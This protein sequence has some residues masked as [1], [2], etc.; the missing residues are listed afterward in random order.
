MS[1]ER[2]GKMADPASAAPG[3]PTLVEF[4]L[5]SSKD[6]YS[7]V[8]SFQSNQTTVRNLRKELESL[9]EALETLRRTANTNVDVTSLNLPLRR[10]ARACEDF[11]DSLN[12]SAEHSSGSRAAFE[13][14][15]KIRYIGDDITDI[16]NVLASC[17]STI[18]IL[19][20]DVNV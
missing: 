20:V 16:K 11:K 10:C 17:K 1:D 19:L 7:T 18:I 8:S 3:I 9:N 14:W 5:Q 2:S 15:A 12:R 6:L 13:D 4:A